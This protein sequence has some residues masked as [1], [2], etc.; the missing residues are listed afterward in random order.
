MK[1]MKAVALKYN[2]SAG[3]EEDIL[4]G[5]SFS[6]KRM[7]SFLQKT[8]SMPVSKT[9]RKPYRVVPH[10]SPFA[11]GVNPNKLNSLVDELEVEAEIAL[12]H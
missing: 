8:F 7:I 11:P 1:I 10:S 3:I 9:F 12:K 4:F 5:K 2:F 6:K